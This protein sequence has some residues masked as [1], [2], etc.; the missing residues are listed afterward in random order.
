[1][2]TT[3]AVLDCQNPGDVPLELNEPN[4]PLLETLICD[5]HNAVLEGGARWGWSEESQAI[6]IGADLDGTADT[7][8]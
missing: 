5:E 2:T 6:L 7:P 3:C 8:S 4:D 1:M